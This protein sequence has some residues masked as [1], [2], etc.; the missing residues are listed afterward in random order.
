VPRARTA[1][2][3]S[4]FAIVAVSTSAWQYLRGEP[5]SLYLTHTVGRGSIES[6][7]T[8]TGTVN[9]FITITVGSYVSGAIQRLYCDYNTRVR[10]GQICAKIDPRPYQAVADQGRANLAVAIAQLEKDKSNLVYSKINY[11]RLA[12]LASSH[13]V[14]RDAVD[15]AKNNYNQAVA[16]IA[17]DEASILQHQAELDAALVNLE[18]TNIASPVAG[19]VVSR[20]VTSGQTVAASYETP[21]LFLIATDFTQ[22]QVDTNV[23]ESDIS[24]VKV[25]NKAS[26]T[27]DAFPKRSFEGVV[28]QVR[29]SP[30]TVQNV[31]TYDVVVSIDNTDLALRPG[32]TAAVKLTVDERH[33]VLR[34]PGEALRYKPTAIGLT[35]A[36]EGEKAAVWILRDG[37]PVRVN[38]NLGISDDSFIE[39]KGGLQPG[40]QVIVSERPGGIP[41]QKSAV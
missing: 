34:V 9:P 14:S 4:L 17:Y 18:Y 41:L 39:V 23:S 33:E 29:Q 32:M 19:T 1:G 26:F 37:S 21:T 36:T 16:Q 6:T 30:Q 13:A 12:G 40:D 8:A 35:T 2:C 15:I 22:M 24:D 27:V 10:P 11:E 31:V 38:L 5:G 20:N 7:I 25:G 3:L 28:A